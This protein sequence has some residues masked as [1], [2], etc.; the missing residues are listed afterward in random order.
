MEAIEEF[1][2]NI[3]EKVTTLA[4]SD[5]FV[6]N[7]QAKQLD[8]EKSE[9]SHSVVAKILYIMKRARPGL[10]IAVYL[11]SGGYQKLMSITGK[12]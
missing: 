11:Y 8:E 4:S 3:D 5:L 9:I 1:G 10:E 6:V 2:E 7:E 12:S